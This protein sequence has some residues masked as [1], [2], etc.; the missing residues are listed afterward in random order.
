MLKK[1]TCPICGKNNGCAFVTG[2][3]PSSCWCMTTSVPKGLLSHVPESYRNISCVCQSCIKNYN[4]RIC[5]VGSLNVDHILNLDCFPKDGET[6]RAEGL[7]EAFGGKGAN[8][9]VACRK[10]GLNTTLLGCV[11][12]DSLGSKYIKHLNKLG[13]E[14]AF[15]QRADVPTG[16]AFIQV[17]KSGENRIIT[18]GGANYQL[19]K[20]WIEKHLEAILEHD[21]FMFSLEIP[22]EIVLYLMEILN[23]HHKLIILDPAPFK[24]FDERMLQFI[25]YI[26]PNESEYDHIKA[27]LNHQQHIVMKRGRKGSRYMNQ[28]IKVN[29]PS[30]SVDTV[31]TIGAGDAFNAALTF[32]L[33]F[34]YTIEE[35]LMFAN[36]AGALSTTENG[37]QEG[38][39]T[40]QRMLQYRYE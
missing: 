20:E 8:Q 21:I 10:L 3:D 13:I 12:N 15:I 19:N 17:D 35:T 5:V 34:N 38:M 14:T 39:P 31:D 32:G 24:N 33:S 18:V 36:I 30:I 2:D 37:A 28:E 11:G 27:G 1:G 9:S 7:E 29:V 16:Q 6:I 22:Q 25:D 4:K 26:T 40:I 23:K